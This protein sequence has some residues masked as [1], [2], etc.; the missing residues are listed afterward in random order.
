MSEEDYEYISQPAPNDPALELI[1]I[2]VDIPLLC[3]F[4]GS[5]SVSQGE[6]CQDFLSACLAQ[7]ER[8]KAWYSR[9]EERIGGSPSIYG[10]GNY[11]STLAVPYHSFLDLILTD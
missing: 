7:M 10:P 4:S 8:H 3:R 5:L 9:W 6:A 11:R 1:H 2:I